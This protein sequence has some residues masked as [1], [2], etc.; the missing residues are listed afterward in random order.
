M[1]GDQELRRPVLHAPSPAPAPAPAPSHVHVHVI[2][3]HVGGVGMHHDAPDKAPVSMP[4]ITP[5]SPASPF[6]PCSKECAVCLGQLSGDCLMP[7]CRHAL[8][9]ECMRNLFKN[10]LSDCPSC[11]GEIVSIVS[12]TLEE[13]PKASK[14]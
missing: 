13:S 5:A 7:Q 11:R 9:S 14:D 10:G 8:H 2:V 3:I 12:E 4:P 6:E 1:R